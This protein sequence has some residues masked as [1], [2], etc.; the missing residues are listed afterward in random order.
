MTA[1]LTK[2]ENLGR[3]TDTCTEEANMKKYL[4]K[5]AIYIPEGMPGSEAG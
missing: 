4:E 3:G 1:F 5:A 2:R